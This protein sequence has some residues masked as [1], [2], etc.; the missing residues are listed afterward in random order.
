MIEPFTSMALSQ[1]FKV[2]ESSS[3]TLEHYQGG[4]FAASRAWAAASPAL[5]DGFIQGYLRGLDWTLDAANREAA[6]EILAINM[7]A[8][9]PAA[10]GRVMDKLLSPRTGLT[11]QAA[12]DLDGIKTVLELRSQYGNGPELSDPGK[13]LDLSYYDRIRSRS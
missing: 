7:P 1:G 6:S 4:I 8:I 11:P 10:I 13:Y 5:L 12:L 9:K 2:L 3:Q